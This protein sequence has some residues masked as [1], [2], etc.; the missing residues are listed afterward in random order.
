MVLSD[1]KFIVLVSKEYMVLVN[2]QIERFNLATRGS[3]CEQEAIQFMLDW[4]L[5]NLLKEVTDA[6]DGP[7]DI[8][9][10]ALA[11]EIDEGDSNI[12]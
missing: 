3:L 7:Q 1:S 9:Q 4:T 11:E 6:K 8:L 2:K 10:G 12:N 5:K